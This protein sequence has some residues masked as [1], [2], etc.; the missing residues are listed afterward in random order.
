MKIAV[1][2]PVYRRPTEWEVV[3]LQQCCKVLARYDHHLVAPEG[4]DTAPFHTLW[5]QHGLNL[6]EERFA[7]KYFAGLQGYN[8]LCLTRDFYARFTDYDYMLIYQPDAFI[9][10]D[11]LADWCQQGY[12]YVGPPNIGLAR[13]T[14]YSP[15]MPMRV[16]NGGFCLRSIAAFL[17]F[18]DGQKRVF[19]LHS[20]LT[21][22]L[23]WQR[24]YWWLV[25]KALVY[26]LQGAEP[27]QILNRWTYN[28]DDFWG[29]LLSL[30]VY[31]LR[32]P[33]PEEA[34]YFGFDRFPKELYARIGQLPM[35]CH[36]WHKYE[37]DTFWKD[38]INRYTNI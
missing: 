18:F 38:I 23:L 24:N 33:S 14:E 7:P 32:K 2:I 36:A 35:G 16:G 19:T 34:L 9:F 29:S 21:S 28:E 20:I 25:A 5:A 3:S 4:L 6:Q 17:R 8:R 26:W 27:V 22:S 31:A 13:Q 11:M 1:V 30:S 15:R 12:E 10:E 37:Y